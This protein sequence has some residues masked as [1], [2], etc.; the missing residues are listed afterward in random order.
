MRSYWTRLSTVTTP[1]QIPRRNRCDRASHRPG[2]QVL[3]QVGPHR[4]D[5]IEKIDEL[6]RARPASQ[7]A[8]LMGD[9]PPARSTCRIFLWSPCSTPRSSRHC[10]RRLHVPASVRVL[11]EVRHPQVCAHGTSHRYISERAAVVLDEPLEDLKLITC[12]LGNGCS[13]SASTMRRCGHL[14][15]FDAARR[16]Y[17]G[18]ALR[19]DRPGHCAVSHGARESHYLRGQ[20]RYEQEVGLARHL[21]RE[22]RPAQRARRLRGRQRA[23]AAR[24]RHVLELGEEIHRCLHCRHGRRRRIVLTA[25]SARTARRCAA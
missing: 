8:A 22:Q 18:H 13:M 14:D 16:P 10:R 12:H 17:D 9:S 7:Q 3:R 23:R 24:L 21:G 15:G 11:R 6:D 4:R 5:V 1:H 2:R 19:R 25:A 20:R